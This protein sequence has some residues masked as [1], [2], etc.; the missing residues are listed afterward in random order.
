MEEILFNYIKQFKKLNRGFNKGL[1]KAPHKPILLISL[2]QL[3]REKLIISNRIYITPKLVLA[4]K[5]N[6]N[7]LVQT[8]HGPNFSLPFFYLKS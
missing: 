1:G 4:F 5:S 6:W 7:I 3:I 2:I 8:K